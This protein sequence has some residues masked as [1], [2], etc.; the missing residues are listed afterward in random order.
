[1][2]R[3]SVKLHSE[4]KAT[5]TVSHPSP[6]K[7]MQTNTKKSKENFPSKLLMCIY[8]TQ[9]FRFSCIKGEGGWGPICHSI[10][11]EVRGQPC[12]AGSLSSGIEAKTSVRQMPSLRVLSH[13]QPTQQ[14]CFKGFIPQNCFFV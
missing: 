1:M 11:V 8:L 7:K 5:W 12:S 9:R 2:G 6:Q 13:S 3:G 14:F 4:F 10:Q